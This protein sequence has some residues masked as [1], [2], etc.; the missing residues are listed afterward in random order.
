MQMKCTC[1]GNDSNYI[2]YGLLIKK[3]KKKKEEKRHTFVFG[4]LFYDYRNDFVKFDISRGET[5]I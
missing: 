4:V 3:K 2:L 5:N 1:N